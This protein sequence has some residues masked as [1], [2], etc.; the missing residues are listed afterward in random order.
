[1]AA[2]VSVNTSHG[3]T[4][5]KHWPVA[6]QKVIHP[7]QRRRIQSCRP[8]ICQNPDGPTRSRIV[9]MGTQP[10]LGGHGRSKP[11]DI[12]QP[13]VQPNLHHELTTILVWDEGWSRHGPG[14]R[15]FAQRGL[16][17]RAV[18]MV[19]NKHANE[20]NS[21]ED[22]NP[23]LPTCSMRLPSQLALYGHKVP[24]NKALLPPCQRVLQSAGE[25][26]RL[27]GALWPALG[28]PAETQ[29]KAI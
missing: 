4:F 29:I 11:R 3:G 19:S 7:S 18:W 17:L 15:R 23:S 5:L 22:E 8:S 26:W 1:M 2:G 14:Y 24:K 16:R 10:D 25:G 28:W 27:L 20:R 13:H 21:N 9:G 6:L 12:L